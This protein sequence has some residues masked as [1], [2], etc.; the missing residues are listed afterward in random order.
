MP[1]LDVILNGSISNAVVNTA[2]I[3]KVLLTNYATT[4]LDLGNVTGTATMDLSQSND[5]TAT[6][7]G[8]TTFSLA[9]Y[10]SSGVVACSLS[11]VNGGAYTLTFTNAKYPGATAPTLS[12]SGID[13]ITFVTYDNGT[14]W[15]GNVIMKD[16]R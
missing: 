11:L 6:L 7:T 1:N 13:T 12:A 2:S 9:N 5:F 8:N 10:P 4:R 15:R 16:S 3:Q 14:T